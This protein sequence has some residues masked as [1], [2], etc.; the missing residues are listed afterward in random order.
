MPLF[1]F[2]CEECHK[3]SEILVRDN[4]SPEC[5]HC[6]A[7]RLVKQASTFAPRMGSSAAP[8]A[9]AGCNASSCPRLREG[10]CPHL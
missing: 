3:R 8:Q 10:A 2:V 9:P 7:R 4:K 6:G 1:E 5:P